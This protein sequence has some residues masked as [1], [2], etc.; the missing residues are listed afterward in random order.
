MTD[1][2]ADSRILDRV[3]MDCT[4]TAVEGVY[5]FPG[6]HHEMWQAVTVRPN[7]PDEADPFA[8]PV[9]LARFHVGD[10]VTVTVERHQVR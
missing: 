8:V 6:D 1:Q 4:V 5:A 3:T 7:S 10:T 9:R 2:P